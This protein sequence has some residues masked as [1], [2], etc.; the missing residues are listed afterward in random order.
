MEIK[1]VF[2]RVCGKTE[3]TEKEAN[4]IVE[5]KICIIAT[6]NMAQLIAKSN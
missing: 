1:F 3:H 4:T 6:G 5:I 2:L